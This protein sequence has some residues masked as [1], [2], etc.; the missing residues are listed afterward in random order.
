MFDKAKELGPEGLDWLK[1]HFAN[2][3]GN[4]KASF[5]DRIKFAEDHVEEI[6]DSALHPLD[7]KRWWLK[8]D[9]P[10][11][12]LAACM[13]L[14]E[15]LALPDPTKYKCHLPVAMDGTC[16]GLQ[17]Y[18]AL[19]GDI[20]GAKQ[21]NLEP[22]EK[23]QDVYKG[24]ADLVN[25]QVD[26]DAAAGDPR[27]LLL[28][29]HISRKVVKQSVMTNVYGVTFMGARAQIENRLKDIPAIPQEKH[30]VLA[31][32]I[33]RLVFDSISKI[34]T[35]ATAIQNWLAAAAKRI[36]R[37]V[38]PDHLEKIRAAANPNDK[39]GAV[40]FMTSVVWTTPLHMPIVQPY[41]KERPQSVRTNLQR[42]FITDPGA[43]EQVHSRKQRTAFPPNF[44]HSLDATH[45]LM[46]AT[47]AAENGLTFASVH[48]SFWTHPSDTPVLNRLLREAFVE[49]HTENLMEK[50]KS[51]FETRY[52]HYRYLT[53]IKFSAKQLAML[54]ELR[55]KRR[56]K[57]G[58]TGLSIAEELQWECER[59]TQTRSDDP[60][61]RAQAEAEITP[62]VLVKSWGKDHD[63]E[64]IGS[65]IHAGET[66]PEAAATEATEDVEIEDHDD[67]AEVVEAEDEDFLSS[68][69]ESD[70]AGEK[71][72]EEIEEEDS[73][74]ERIVIGKDKKATYA[75]KWTQSR[76]SYIWLPL[77]FPALPKKVRIPSKHP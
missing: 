54:I 75:P 51:E 72:V 63:D 16:N 62:S 1:I 67:D 7:G 65:G 52:K 31:T 42:V 53:A 25:I 36:S 74:I 43:I 46:S 76:N 26:K 32:Y 14:H 11:Q 22:S 12:C 33:T 50:L 59:D 18:A 39:N 61:V 9:D 4:D 57:I 30:A 58:R 13:A 3:S 49:L 60:A 24:V 64:V 21:V 37:S 56:A 45:M 44:I 69:Q 15:A 73:L 28:Q 2:V 41:R 5:E 34:F 71:E 23:P 6:N 8:S 48:D 40:E 68:A 27:A 19:G 29:G 35:G 66:E 47:K 77:E 38:N 17:H 20:V 55:D 70:E 10:W